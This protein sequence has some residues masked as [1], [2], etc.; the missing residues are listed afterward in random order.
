M[1]APCIHVEIESFELYKEV[2][3]GLRGIGVNVLF[4]EETWE[5][6]KVKICSDAGE[7]ACKWLD[8][9]YHPLIQASPVKSFE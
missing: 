2:F 9:F 6:D 4:N 3:D 7:I 1:M 5:K 8:Q